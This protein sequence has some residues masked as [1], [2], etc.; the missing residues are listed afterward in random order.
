MSS[1]RRA[2]EVHYY[3][4]NVINV[5]RVI[6]LSSARN[7]E[8]VCARYYVINDAKNVLFP[9]V[10]FV[11]LRLGGIRRS[12]CCY[13]YAQF[14]QCKRPVLA[15]WP[16]TLPDSYGPNQTDL[17]QQIKVQPISRLQAICEY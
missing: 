9:F 3:V 14:S 15:C 2:D 13:A 4:H 12:G 10:L 7:R 17:R 11:Q 6:L 8:K 1:S 16:C 5:T